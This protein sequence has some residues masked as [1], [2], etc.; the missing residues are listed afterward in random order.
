MDEIPQRY[1]RDMSMYRIPPMLL[2]EP[3]SEEALAAT[4]RGAAGAGV[5]LTLRGGGSGTGGA[6]LGRQVV[7]DLRYLEGARELTRLGDGKVRAGAAV[8]HDV[9]QNLLGER[10]YHLPADPS[11][12]Q[13]SLIG[14]NIATKAS[15][16]HAL[17]E[18]AINRYIDS[19]RIMLADGRVID[20]GADEALPPD[21]IRKLTALHRR[22][23]QSPDARNRLRERRDRKIASGYNLQ[24]IID[25][26]EDAH[27]RM[28]EQLM[29]GSAGTLGVVLSASF[30]GR[31]LQSERLTLSVPLRR[32]ASACEFAL[33]CAEAGAA[34]VEL[35][36]SEAIRF[37]QEM[38]DELPAGATAETQMLYVELRGPEAA[39]RRRRI[40][41]RAQRF[42]GIQTDAVRTAE[43]PEE[44]ERIW[45]L[46]K[47]L[48]LRIRRAPKPLAAL[49][50][51][52]DVGVPPQRL[53]ELIE[54]V[55]EIFR[56]E[57]LAAPI[58]GHAASGNLHLRPLFDTSRSDLRE[59][60][61]RSADAV[62]GEVIR[63]DGTVTAEH[64]MGRLRA[65][66]LE[67]EWGPEV[68][69]LF[70]RTKT[71]F[72]PTGLFNPEAL[73]Y[74]GDPTTDIDI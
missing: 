13:L 37:L 50:V 29:C 46:R 23:R 2:V 25:L 54:R 14:G 41:Q 10:G 17:S 63:L 18:G 6:A 59:Q 66:V 30:E 60:I 33:E 8:R 47:R 64:G 39:E 3:R 68:Y 69:E 51:V 21:L 57:G 35:I 55:A 26:P 43:D 19:M 16:A 11:S 71:C 45:E 28:I 70:Q 31:E 7:A 5:Q 52:N 62:Y 72:D 1:S 74:T 53:H 36:D 40:I 67:A 34:A 56:R 73:F 15:G 65:P 38:G 61:R 44:Q 24:S 9:V 27:R 58:Y 49:S 32:R 48:L 12:W 22:I 20:T 42:P 4:L